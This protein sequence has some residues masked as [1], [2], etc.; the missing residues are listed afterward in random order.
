M[1]FSGNTDDKQADHH[2][3]P[4]RAVFARRVRPGI[5]TRR[6]TRAGADRCSGRRSVHGEASPQA[7]QTPQAPR[8]GSDRGVRSGYEALS[9]ELVRV[10][11]SP[12]GKGYVSVRSLLLAA[13]AALRNADN[14]RGLREYS[15]CG[16]FE[17]GHR[18]ASVFR[19]DGGR[20]LGA[21]RSGLLPRQRWRHVGEHCEVVQARS[22]GGCTLEQ[23]VDER[24]GFGRAGTACCAAGACRG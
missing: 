8:V 21:C 6:S 11:A 24:C 18:G 3:H 9:L 22:G 12:V 20:C 15:S 14:A 23:D 10:R 19:F 5:G 7:S 13:S 4:R 1:A 16:G 2:C 17:R